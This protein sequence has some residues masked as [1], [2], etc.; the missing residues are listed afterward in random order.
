M[1]MGQ[2]KRKGGCGITRFFLLFAMVHITCLFLP[3][4]PLPAVEAASTATQGSSG[5]TGTGVVA[6]IYFSDRRDLETLASG[7][8]IWEVNHEEGFIVAALGNSHYEALQRSGAVLEIDHEKTALL[9]RPLTRL[10]G[11]A[12]GIPGLPCYRTVEETYEAMRSLAT[13]Y[14]DLASLVPIGESWERRYYG[15]TRGFTLTVLQL[16]KRNTTGNKPKFFLMGA[17]HAREL[18][19]AE[20]VIRFAEF[21]LAGYGAEP[22][23]TWLLDHFEIHLLPVANPDGRKIAEEGYYQR[24]NA[25]STNGG[26]CAVPPTPYSQFG[27]DLNRNSTFQWGGDSSSPCDMTYQGATSLSEPETQA[28]QAYLTTL[29]PDQRGPGDEDPVPLEGSGIFITL[30][31]YGNLVLWPW[32]F[33]SSRAPNASQFRVLGHKLAYFNSYSPQQSWDLYRLTGSND[34]WA[35]GELGVASYTFEMGTQFFQ[36]CSTFEN[37]IYPGNR[38]ALLY[39]FKAARRP[40]QNPSGPDVTNVTLSTTLVV[41]GTKITLA[42]TA[43]LTGYK[44]PSPVT[45]TVYV[46]AARYSK[47]NPSWVP[48]TVTFS[49]SPSDGAFNGRTEKVEATVDTG[50]WEPGRHTL[51]IEGRSSTGNWGPPRAV[52]VEILPPA[53]KVN[54]FAT[55]EGSGEGLLYASGLSCEASLCTGAYE[56]EATVEVTATA[57]EGSL[58]TGWSGCDST[59]GPVCRVKMTEERTIHTRFEPVL[60]IFHIEGGSWCTTQRRVTLSFLPEETP[61]KT[62]IRAVDRPCGVLGWVPYRK[63][64]PW[65]LGAG[66]G[67]KRLYVWFI[68]GS[69]PSAVKGPYPASIVYSPMCPTGPGETLPGGG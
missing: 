1:T 17:A 62:C 60:K 45:R 42:A 2:A 13:A 66:Q 49:M 7:L 46:D 38:D 31:S 64:R 6:R 16:T 15:N 24:K 47:D 14:P 57:R 59:R 36:D 52:F 27:T 37:T 68:T 34:D 67:V 4:F 9:D 8:D 44:A 3:V 69:R 58:F 50:D 5:E 32:G 29:F 65:I 48:G 55:L 26:E 33:T 12:S 54:L 28:L 56:A 61:K 39:A 20:T 19:T 43:D 35:Y 10:A 63:T 30:H 11:Q 51:L 22:D 23:I 40:Y 25:N 53:P 41:S 21:L 18:V